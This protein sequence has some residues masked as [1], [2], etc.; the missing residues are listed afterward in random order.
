MIDFM[1]FIETKIFRIDPK[2][3][4]H[5]NITTDATMNYS[6]KSEAFDYYLSKYG[7]TRCQGCNGYGH[8]S[9]EIKNES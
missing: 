4:S 5:S 9:S 6:I 3:R 7:R 8:V 1:F 2:K